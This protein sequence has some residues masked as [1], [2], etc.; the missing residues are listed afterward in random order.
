MMIKKI[1]M[2]KGSYWLASAALHHRKIRRLDGRLKRFAP[3]PKLES[4]RPWTF[5][6]GMNASFCFSQFNLRRRL[7]SVTRP[8]DP[9]PDIYVKVHGL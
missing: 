3:S 4:L 9:K 2:Y 5:H 7:S 1:D 8:P 6:N